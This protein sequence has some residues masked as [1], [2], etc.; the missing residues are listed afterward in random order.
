MGRLIENWGL[1]VLPTNFPEFTWT[2]VRFNVHAVF[3]ETYVISPALIN[4]VR[5]GLYKEKS[6][7]GDPL[8]GVT[9]FKGDAAVKDLGLLG[10]NPK[11]YSAQ[12][13]PVM[14]ITGYPRLRTAAWWRGAERP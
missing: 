3:E 8:Y 14:N 13:F 6:T 9:P 2:R 5:V 1:Y 12:G 4:S 11:G 10:V 7:D